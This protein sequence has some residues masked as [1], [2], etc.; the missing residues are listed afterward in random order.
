MLLTN[1]DMDV[2]VQNLFKNLFAVSK[3]N[4]IF[5]IEEFLSWIAACFYSII[6]NAKFKRLT[7]L[8]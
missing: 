3:K 6:I 4:R 2:S 5:S 8:K 1:M 7:D